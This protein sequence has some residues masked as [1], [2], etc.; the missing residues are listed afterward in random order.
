MIARLVAEGRSNK[1][2]A[3]ELFISAKTVEHHLSRICAKLGV[4]GRS[5]LPAVFP[6]RPAVGEIPDANG[7]P[8]PSP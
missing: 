8:P 5:H 6:E 3:A 2:V 7:G 4:R 1:D